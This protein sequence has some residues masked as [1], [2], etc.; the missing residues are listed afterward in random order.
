MNTF[1]RLALLLTLL[2]AVLPAHAQTTRK[3][4]ARK[5]ATPSSK[6]VK[7]K[8]KKPNT[9][10]QKT[11]VTAEPTDVQ[12][13]ESPQPLVFGDPEQPTPPE[14]PVTTDKPTVA[15]PVPPP[16]TKPHEPVNPNARPSLANT[17]AVASG[18]VA[19]FSVARTP[20]TT[21]AAARLEGELTRHLQRGGDIPFVDLGTAFPPPE[22]TPLTQADGLY[23]EGRAAYDNLDPEAAETKF[24]AAAEAYEKSPGDFRPE[25]LGETYLFLGAARLLNGDAAGA[26]AAFVRAAVAEP[27]TRPD[28]A[29]FGQDVQKAFEDA[30]AEVSARP[31]GTLVVESKPAGAKVSVRG[32]E[33]GVTPLRGVTVPAGHH[34]VVVTLPGHTPHAEYTEVKSGASAQ[35]K[36]EL[37][38]GPGLTAIRDASARA[39]SQAAFDSETLPPDTAAIADRLDARYVVVAAVSQDKKGR[40]KAELQAWDVRT[41]ARLRGVDIDLSGR[42]RD[43]SPEAAAQQARDFI[44]GAI[45]PRVAESG[46]SGQSLLKRPWFWA[47]VGG[48]AAVTAGAVFVATQDKGRPFNPITGGTGF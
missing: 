41:Q 38:P 24:R 9:K 10:G 42:E 43:Q 15:T 46:A 39:G 3:K 26:K 44:Q 20:A 47:V 17:P 29:L 16:A 5:K 8:K 18:T 6:V 25:R 32:Q 34:A 30:R 31:A 19:L 1:R 11:P 2:L 12:D 7:A 36:A 14:K 37:S 27:S 23:D 21:E 40:L 13:V 33:L 28:K 22:P 48:A 35:V 4:A 45:S